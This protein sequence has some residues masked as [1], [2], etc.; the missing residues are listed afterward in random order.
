[1]SYYNGQNY[2]GQTHNAQQFFRQQPPQG[3]QSGGFNQP[4]ITGGY[5]RSN[6]NVP[7]E[8]DRFAKSQ[9]P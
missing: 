3:F 1:M 7:E 5:G 2:Y 4:I 6:S 8:I 9:R